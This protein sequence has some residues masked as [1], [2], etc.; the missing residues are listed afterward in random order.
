VLLFLDADVCVHPDTLSRVADAFAADP[1]LAALMGSYDDQPA[2]PSFLSQYKNLFHHYVHQHGWKE[3]S[4]FWSGCGAVRRSLFL[5]MGGFNEGY[6]RPCIEDIELGFRLRRAGHRIRLEK[7]IQAQHLKCWRFLDL[8]KTDLFLRGVPW[9]ALMLRDRRAVKDLNLSGRSR[10]C[11]ILTYLLAL[12]LFA[13]AVIGQFP[14]TFPA[15]AIIGLGVLV[16]VLHDRV[17]TRLRRPL[18]LA[19]PALGVS[20]LV[21]V[22]AAAGSLQPAAL[23]P[24]GLLLVIV[25][26]HLSFYCFFVRVRGLGFAFGVLPLHLLFFLYSGL[27]IP[28]GYLAYRRD[29]RRAVE[30]AAGPGRILV[31]PL[32]TDEVMR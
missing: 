2:H 9:V 22:L 6:T 12:A 27:A 16:P 5:A 17:S 15:L 32:K 24:V 31:H 1:D 23:L 13:L 14:A 8:V 19:I 20:A 7:E 30:E 21:P 26:I 10:L 28:L 11:A 3:A 25:W 18:T 4:T 29:R